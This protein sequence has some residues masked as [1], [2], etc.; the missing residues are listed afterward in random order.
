[1]FPPKQSGT[2]S[3]CWVSL[4]RK[5]PASKIRWSLKQSFT[6]WLRT[7]CVRLMIC[8][9]I[10]P[11]QTLGDACSPLPVI[12]SFWTLDQQGCWPVLPWQGSFKSFQHQYN[13][14]WAHSGLQFCVCWVTAQCFTCHHKVICKVNRHP[15]TSWSYCMRQFF[16]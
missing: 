2:A 8:F 11:P 3:E 9:L 4:S 10:L 1:M 14:T 16:S 6:R 12:R 13:I 7:S 5:D 15:R